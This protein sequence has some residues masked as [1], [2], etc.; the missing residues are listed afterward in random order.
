MKIMF[1]IENHGEAVIIKIEEH[2]EAIIIKIEEH[3]EVGIT[4]TPNTEQMTTK[5]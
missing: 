1:N 5:T 2:G 4:I 3:G